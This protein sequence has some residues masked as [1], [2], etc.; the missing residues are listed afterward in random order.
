MVIRLAV[1]PAV[2]LEEVPRA[3]LLVAVSAREV[4]RVPGAAQGRDHLRKESSVGPLHWPKYRNRAR[5]L[6]RLLK[7]RIENRCKSSQ[8]VTSLH[9]WGSKT[10]QETGHKYT[11][12]PFQ[13]L[14]DDGLLAGVAASLLGGLYSLS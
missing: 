2:T 9:K 12:S 10:R 3:Q 8:D 7:R 6:Q 14:S 13:H 1:G 5:L 4:L 11:A